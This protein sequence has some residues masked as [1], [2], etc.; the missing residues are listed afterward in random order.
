MKQ[1]KKAA[2]APLL[3]DNSAGDR[4]DIFR[5]TIARLGA[6]IDG[7]FANVRGLVED[8][9]REG[10][11]GVFPEMRLPTEKL[12][13]VAADMDQQ[14]I[15]YRQRGE[16]FCTTFEPLLTNVLKLELV[17]YELAIAACTCIAFDS[18][19]DFRRTATL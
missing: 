2:A 15:H 5:H 19:P 7:D 1:K 6:C 16:E 13:A 8:A 10:S 17:R 9:C 18:D 3:T 4:S 14:H 12:A 11:E